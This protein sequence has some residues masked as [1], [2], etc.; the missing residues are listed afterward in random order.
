MR[1]GYLAAGAAGMYCGACLHDNTLAAALLDLGEDVV[2][3]PIYTPLRTDETDVSVPRVFIGGINAYLQQHIPLLRR[4]PR[5]LD[6][7]L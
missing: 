2:L 6:G 4:T 5:W 1:I 3:A 7:W